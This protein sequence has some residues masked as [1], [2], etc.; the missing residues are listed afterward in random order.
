MI[1]APMPCTARTALSIAMSCAAAQASEASVKM[2][3]ADR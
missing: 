2:D 1:A 3:K